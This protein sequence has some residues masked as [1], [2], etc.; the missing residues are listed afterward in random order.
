MKGKK[1]EYGFTAFKSGTPGRVKTRSIVF[2]I[3][4]CLTVFFEAFYW[5]F[6]NSVEPFVL[7]MPTGMFFITLFIV[8]QFIVLVILYFLE[9]KDTEKGGTK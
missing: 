2:F 6:A 7:G 8:I 5:L 1:S 3:I 4:L 9:A